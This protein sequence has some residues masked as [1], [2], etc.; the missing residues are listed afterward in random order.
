MPDKSVDLPT[1]QRRGWMGLQAPGQSCGSRVG[2][3]VHSS[4]AALMLTVRFDSWG[5]HTVTL[6]GK[7]SIVLLGEGRICEGWVR[8]G[9][10][11]LREVLLDE[12][13][14]CRSKKLWRRGGDPGRCVT[15]NFR[16]KGLRVYLC[17]CFHCNIRKH[18]IP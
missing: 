4:L 14:L 3:A 15:S 16:G 2:S 12:G 9:Y 18:T 11:R 13:R 1:P 17:V 6:E 8:G 7:R 5:L 10:V